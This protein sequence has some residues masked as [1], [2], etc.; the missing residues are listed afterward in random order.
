VWFRK[1][2]GKE[3]LEKWAGGGECEV[4]RESGFAEV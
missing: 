3:G 2:V 4:T 1:V